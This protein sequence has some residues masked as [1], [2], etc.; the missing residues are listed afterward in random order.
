[1]HRKNMKLNEFEDLARWLQAE[2][3]DTYA[4]LIWGLPGETADTF[5]KGYDRISE[6]VSKIAIYPHLI[7]PNT[8][9][10]KNRDRYGLGVAIEQIA[11]PALVGPR[12]R[13]P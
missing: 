5:I 9:F 10:D 13:L 4:E 2:G 12:S 6:H 3:L 7:L 1:M 11:G 8:D